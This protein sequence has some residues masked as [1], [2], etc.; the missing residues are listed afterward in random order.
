MEENNTLTSMDPI[1]EPIPESDE[2]DSV[3]QEVAV[4]VEEAPVPIWS[5]NVPSKKKQILQKINQ[6]FQVIWPLMLLLGSIA[7][8][9]YYIFFPARGE[10]HSDCTDTLYWAEAAMQGNGLIN[11]D[12]T[13]AALMPFG[14]NLF[15]QIWIP[16]FGISMT[17]HTLGMATFFVFFVGSLCLMLR[18]MHFGLRSLSVTVSGLLMTLCLSQKIRE[19]FWGHIIYYSLGI[20]F[21]FIGLFLV[22]RIMNLSERRPTKGILV[23]KIVF[24]VLL[25]VDFIIC[26]TNSTTAIALFA[27]PIIGGVFCERFL[28]CRT[29]LRS[30]K[31]YTAL[32][33]L[34]ICGIGLL[35]GMKWGAAIAG[36]V[37][38]GYAEAY[39]KFSNTDE[40]WG[41]VE[42]LPLA[43][44]WMLG[45]EVD[46]QDKL[47]SIEGVQVIL[48]IFYALFL[49]IIPVIA[50][51]CYRK[52]KETGVRILIWAHWIVTAF[53]LVGY[54]CGLLSAGNW[55]ISPAI[56]TGVLV[57][58]A[59]LRWLYHQVEYKRLS[60]LLCIP[61]AYICLHSGWQVVKMPKDSYKTNVNYELGEYLKEQD[62]TYGYASF[63]HS[64][65]ITVL[66]DSEVKVRTVDFSD[67][68][69]VTKSLYQNNQNW[70]KDQPDQDRYFLLMEQG[71][72]DKLNMSTSLLLTMSHE[73]LYYKGYTIWV[74]SENIFS[75]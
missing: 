28:D 59:F 8:V 58:F 1:V 12:F 60:I 53:I 26:C 70:F 6:F 55:R 46:N 75:E 72:L 49:A 17:T 32:F 41:H 42:S 30:R 20:L 54:F 14:G 68:N 73:E 57:S 33:I 64:Q 74:F 47:A 21:L 18:E 43:F 36:D 52:I 13:Y 71:E 23:Q 63:W 62:L 19:I 10:F 2:T 31:N 27:L 3:I 56:C 65:A 24:M 37:R 22:L 38:G 34:V 16:F 45:L 61:L 40:W 9:L 69:G 7:V 5:G 50:L 35:L 39:S 66:E 51:C 29:R 15:M 25:A 44:L 48:T 11:P 67:V 4:E